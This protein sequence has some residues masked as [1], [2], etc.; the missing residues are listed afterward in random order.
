MRPTRAGIVMKPTPEISR[1]EFLTPDEYEATGGKPLASTAE[2]VET[3]AAQ[4]DVSTITNEDNNESSELRNRVD[5]D[6]EG[7]P[8]RDRPEEVS[9]DETGQSPRRARNADGQGGRRARATA[10]GAEPGTS[11]Q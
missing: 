9:A 1:P 6:G 5:D 10:E 2:P 4:L 8:I 11:G 7:V 3:Q